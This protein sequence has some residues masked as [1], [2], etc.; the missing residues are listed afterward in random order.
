MGTLRHQYSPRLAFEVSAWFFPGKSRL[1]SDLVLQATSTLLYPYEIC[2][3]TEYQGRHDSLF[4]QTTI[5]PREPAFPPVFISIRRKLFRR[6]DSVQGRL[7]IDLGSYPQVAVS[8]VSQNPVTLLNRPDDAYV[9]LLPLARTV[10]SWSHGFVLNSY[11]PKLVGQWG[12]AFTELS[13]QCKLG[14]ECGLNGLAWLF[15]GSWVA[16]D[17]SVAATIRL[18][19]AGVVLTLELVLPH[20]ILF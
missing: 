8:I 11:D 16:K 3:R 9:S 6:P 2:L 12:L 18:N 13:L 14:L 4:V 10:F 20:L 19:H 15:S 7:K 1:F 17:L 5:I